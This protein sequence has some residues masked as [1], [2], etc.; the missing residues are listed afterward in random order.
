MVLT[1]LQ[2]GPILGETTP[3]SARIW[4]RGHWEPTPAGPRRC[5]GAAR[6]RP[7]SSSHYRQPIFFK[8]NPNFDLTGVARFENLEPERLYTYQVGCFFADVELEALTP[9]Y[10]LVWDA[11][12]SQT[13]RTASADP[14]RA[15]SFFV[16]SCRYLLRLLGG[17]W[18]DQRG[19]K[20]FRSM[21]AQLD[22]GRPADALLMLGDQIYADDLGLPSDPSVEAYNERYQIAFGQPHIRQLMGRVPTYMTLDDHEIANDWPAGASGRD[23]VVRYP[24]A[25]H[26]LLTYQLSHSPLLPM[27]AP[28]QLAGVP[29][30]LWYT[31]QDGVCDFFVTDTRTER[32]LAEDVTQRALISPI[33]LAALQAWL[34]DGAPRVKCVVSSVPFFPD[35]ERNSQDKWAGFPAQR[36]AVLETIRQQGVRRVLFLGGDVHVSTSAKLICPQDPTFKVIGLTASPFFWPY[37]HFGRR[38]LQ[39]SGDLPAVAPVRYQLSQTGPVYAADNFTRV[40]VDETGVVVETF[41]RKGEVL[42]VRRHAF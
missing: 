36:G 1:P 12:P 27:T 22:A 38:A 33:Q 32:L 19:D 30:K 41:G 39:L 2:L 29:E 16:G 40:T 15:R 18:F 6:L 3:T 14:T 24:A 26:A 25:I 8:L 35:P 11:I 31:F 21:L 37:P 9:A 4:G 28:N 17:T 13:F 42:G 5:F 23:E 34:T 20:T 7:A 10:P